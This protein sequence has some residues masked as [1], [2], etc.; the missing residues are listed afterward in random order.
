MSSI[1]IRTTPN[2]GEEKVNIQLNQDFDFIEILSLKITQDEVY[3]RYS[4]NYGVVVGRVVVNNGLTIILFIVA[5]LF[6]NW[7]F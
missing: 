4:S 7:N 1:R 2:S 6:V 5:W 3:K